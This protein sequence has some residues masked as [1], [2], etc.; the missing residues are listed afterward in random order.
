MTE[1]SQRLQSQF[2]GD[3][4]NRTNVR[5]FIFQLTKKFKNFISLDAEYADGY[6]FYK[7][8]TISDYLTQSV[9]S[10]SKFI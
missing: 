1:S 8:K 6:D 10:V 2:W 4:Q 9:L 3:F 5:V 7:L